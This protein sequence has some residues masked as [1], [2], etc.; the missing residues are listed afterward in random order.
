M[1]IRDRNRATHDQLK[2]A[3]GNIKLSG[4]T[5]MNR[6]VAAR[7]SRLR[8]ISIF[9]AKDMSWSICSLGK[10][11]KNQMINRAMM[12]T[13]AAS[14]RG[15][16]KNGPRQPPRKRVEPAMAQTVTLPH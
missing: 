10:V 4:Q 6:L 13:L 7:L 5:T 14:Q 12:P 11:T 8:G 1:C 15:L 2:I 9:Q 16:L 3:V